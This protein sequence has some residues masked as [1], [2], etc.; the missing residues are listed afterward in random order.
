MENLK[1][2]MSKGKEIFWLNEK[3]M[4]NSANK[5]LPFTSKRSEERR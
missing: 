1:K 2:K 3:L 5:T 4:R